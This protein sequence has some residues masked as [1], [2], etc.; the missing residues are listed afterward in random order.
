MV[1]VAVQ[2]EP[3]EGFVSLDD[4]LIF[5]SREEWELLDEAQKRLYYRVMLETVGLAISVRLGN[6]KFPEITQPEPERVFR[7]PDSVDTCFWEQHESSPSFPG[8][9]SHSSTLLRCS[10]LL[11]PTR[12]YDPCKV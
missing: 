12:S 4:V 2:T 10:C 1:D 6:S 7:V 8:D 9:V 11:R 3:P 5:F